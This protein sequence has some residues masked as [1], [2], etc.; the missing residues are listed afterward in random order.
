MPVSQRKP[1]KKIMLER[2]TASEI[3]SALKIQ[4]ID[5][6]R[7]EAALAAVSKSAE[8]KS[9]SSYEVKAAPKAIKSSRGGK[10]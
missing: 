5:R 10:R 7:A 9:V 6:K 8:K 2:S 3:R 4:P 1:V